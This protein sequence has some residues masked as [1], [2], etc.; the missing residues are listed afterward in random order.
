MEI[1]THPALLSSSLPAPAPATARH[2]I[3]K[4]GSS[5]AVRL[6]LTVGV[7]EMCFNSLVSSSAAP[8]GWLLTGSRASGMM[9]LTLISA[10]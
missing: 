4:T 1:K 7:E 5:R 2:K 9:T 6:L 8:V 3:C 10:P